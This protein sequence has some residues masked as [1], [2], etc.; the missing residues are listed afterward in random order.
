MITGRKEGSM[1]RSEL[2]LFV[3]LTITLSVLY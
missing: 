1:M 2:D 3:T